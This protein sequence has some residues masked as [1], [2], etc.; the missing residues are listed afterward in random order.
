MVITDLV[1][2]NKSLGF[3]YF[4]MP[5]YIRN[6]IAASSVKLEKTF[7]VYFVN[8]K[9]VGKLVQSM[10]QLTF[11]KQSLRERISPGESNDSFLLD[12]I[13]RK[14]ARGFLT[15]DPS[16]FNSLRDY[17]GIV[18][19]EKFNIGKRELAYIQISDLSIYNS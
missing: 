11:G 12:L 1:D 8:S 15:D 5:S 4:D 2:E 16:F 14:E 3:D 6:D 19:R 9:N 18:S 10:G 13:E 17:D 7:P